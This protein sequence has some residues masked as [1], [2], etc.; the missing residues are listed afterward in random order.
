MIDDELVARP[1][2]AGAHARPSGAARHR[3][4]PRR[5]LPGAR[6]GRIRSTAPARRIVAEAMDRFADADRPAVPACSTT[7]AHPEAERVIVIMG[8]GAETVARDGRRADGA[9][10]EGR[11]AQ[12]AA[13]PA[14]LGRRTSSP[15]CRRPCRRIAVLDRTKEPGAL[16]EPL[17]LDV[18]AALARG[19]REARAA[20]PRVIGGRYGLS[21]KEFTPGDGQGGLRRAR[22][23]A[24]PQQPLHR[25]HRRRRH[26]HEPRLRPGV[27]HRAA[28]TCARRVLRPR[29]RRHGRRQ[30]ELDQD[31][32]RGD[33]QL[34]PGLL[35]LR[36]EEVGRD[37]RLAPAL[38]P[39]ADPLALP[40][41]RRRQLRR[42][43]PVRVPRADRRARARRAGRASSCSTA[44]TA[45]T[46]SGTSCRARCRSRSSRRSCASTS[47]DAGRVA[48]RGRHGRPHQHD[49]ADLLLRDLRRAA[50]RR[51]D[52]RRSSTPIEKTYGKRGAEVV[53]AELRRRR[54]AR[55]AHLHEVPVPAAATAT[56]AGRRRSSA[57]GARVRAEGHR[58][59][60]G[61]QGRPAAGQRLARRRHLADRH[62]A[63]G[64]AQHRRSRS[65]SGTRRSASSATSACWSARTPPSAPRST[66]AERSAAPP[67][68]FKSAPLQWPRASRTQ[69]YTIQ[70]APED[71]TGCALCVEVCP[72]KDKTEPAPQGDRHAAAGAARASRSGS[73]CDFFLDLPEIDRA[74]VDCRRRSRARSSCE[75]LFEFSGACAGCGETPY[76][77]LL[78]Q[79]FGDRLLIANAT[80]CSSI[81]GGNLPTTP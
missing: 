9:R 25:R 19:A 14:V 33:R 41:S 60:D 17:Y 80:G 26:A 76:L 10:R 79:L 63:V 73:N 13:V 77:K 72:A 62:G 48:A 30:Q 39:A 71:C 16:G 68:G 54:R 31:H 58:R 40:R 46:R 5:L 75:P 12:G 64:E 18:V 56:P 67:D 11:R 49:H 65:R 34:R 6:G 15:R 32:R 22:R 50:A 52:R 42:L 24:R 2:R 21:S 28:T 44:R 59:D 7:S 27:R 61:R 23:R 35:R 8:S 70:V 81:Y 45:R 43:P 74:A 66:T 53:R 47:I 38:R 4:E 3:A 51:G 57:D 78:T 29:R 55:S 69:R 1:P 36:L 20:M 37:D